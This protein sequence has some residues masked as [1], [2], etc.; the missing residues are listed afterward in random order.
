MIRPLADIGRWLEELVSPAP[1]VRFGVDQAR[2]ASK[3]RT[4]SELGPAAADAAGTGPGAASTNPRVPA[5]GRP[6]RIEQIDS[7]DELMKHHRCSWVPGNAG[8]TASVWSC[9]GCAWA[10]TS[11]SAHERHQAELVVDMLRA[12]ARMSAAT[13]KFQQ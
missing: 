7:T 13:N 2:Q 4:A 11:I 5:P 9:T 3:T 6:D 8:T 1:Q 12:D 10:G